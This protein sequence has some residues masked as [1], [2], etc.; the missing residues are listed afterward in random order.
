MLNKKRVFI[1]ENSEKK[2]KEFY[3]VK[4]VLNITEFVPDFFNDIE[5]FR[6]AFSDG[7]YTD[8]YIICYRGTRDNPFPQYISIGKDDD[9][10]FFK[11]LDAAFNIASK[12]P[13]SNPIKVKSED[14][15]SWPIE[16][17]QLGLDV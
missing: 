9:L 11:T 4:E 12:I 14:P 6:A 17:E 15:L 10:R 13:C 8:W 1:V 5:I 2:F 16:E 3:S 7:T